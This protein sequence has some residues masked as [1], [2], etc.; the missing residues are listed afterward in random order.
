MFIISTSDGEN[1]V[2]GK[3]FTD[4]KGEERKFTWDDLPTTSKIS[5]I[6]LS[7]PF[8]VKFRLSDGSVAEERHPKLT[9]NGFDRYYF[10]NE[11]IVPMQVSGMSPVAAGE[12]N[13]TAK[14]IAGIDDKT[15][16]VSQY[17]MDKWGNVSVLQIP[18]KSI[19]K[20]IK[21]GTF[22]KEIIRQG[23]K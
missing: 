8:P 16:M 11:A 18:L 6:Q 14:I 4:D 10:A 13:L 1:F 9:I 17:R 20:Q 2:E 15:K 3:T 21:D 22:K 23:S 12:T 5:S 7:Y 19:E